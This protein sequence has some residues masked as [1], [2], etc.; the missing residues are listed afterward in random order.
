MGRLTIVLALM[1]TGCPPPCGGLGDECC[2]AAPLCQEGLACRSGVT[3]T[4]EDVESIFPANYRDTFTEV[5]DCRTSID[6]DL[7]YVRIWAN[8]AAVAPYEAREERLPDGSVFVKE[9]YMDPLCAGD[10]RRWTVMRREDDL[11]PELDGW[12]FQTTDPTGAVLE[13]GAT[14]DCVTCH[15]NECGGTESGFDGTCADP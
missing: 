3:A 13:D 7:V 2:A 15:L 14:E 5:R 11:Y 10:L 9:E 6:H 12:H 4:C 1:T 8:P